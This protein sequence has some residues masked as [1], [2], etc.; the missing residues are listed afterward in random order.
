MVRVL[1]PAALAVALACCA[2]RSDQVDVGIGTTAY[3]PEA[4]RPYAELYLP[5]A[6]MSAL[7]Y[8]DPKFLTVAAPHYGCPSLEQL[9]N[10]KLVDVDHTAAE[11]NIAAVWLTSLHHR[12]WECLFGKI[13]PEGCPRGEECVG[14]LEYHAWLRRD[15]SEAVVAF[16]GSDPRDIGDW[17]SNLR[18]FVL[19]PIFDQY[20]QV[21]KA[22]PRII[23]RI[24]AAGC[25]PRKIIA[26]G[27]SLGGGL[28]QHAAYA[29]KRIGYVYAF[30]PSPVTAFFGVPFPQRSAATEDLGIDRI[31]E[32]GEILS[33]PRYLA[34]GLFPTSQCR[35]R[36]RIVRFAT[37]K[38][39]SLLERH[40]IANFTRGLLE[41]SKKGKPSRL[42]LG[43]KAAH[44]CTFA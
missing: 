30:D 31:Y 27:H 16:R 15:C 3:T 26:T 9:N 6:Q 17:I 8:T 11:N 39:P 4:A 35:P 24:S 38:Q 32:A 25:R 34:S 41:L 43:Y 10:P 29:D 44:D 22:I 2:Q 7:A 36:V 19:S 23:D 28:G 18:W 1:L 42:P 20:D 12:G 40:A 37:A 13:G 14:G 33:L 5:Y 21:Q